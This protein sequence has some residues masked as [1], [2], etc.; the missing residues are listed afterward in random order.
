MWVAVGATW[1]IRYLAWLVAI[2]KQAINALE[3]LERR[4]VGE[5]WW[6]VD[7]ADRIHVRKIGFVA[8]TDFDV[9][10]IREF[11]PV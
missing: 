2:D 5:P 3:S 6:A 9:T 11:W 10:A 4:D 7:I 8:I 1:E